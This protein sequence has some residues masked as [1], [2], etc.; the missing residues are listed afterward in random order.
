MQT[1]ALVASS[2]AD[3]SQQRELPASQ[4]SITPPAPATGRRLAFQDLK[5]TLTNEE[6]ANPGTQ[7]LIL[8][9]LTSAELDRDEFKAYVPRYYESDKRASVLEEK[10]RTNKSNEILTGTCIGLGGTIIGL[11]PTFWSNGSVGPITLGLGLLFVIGGVAGRITF[12]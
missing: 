10:L 7:K 12:K 2:A 5:R 9:M 1:P 3:A 11:A 6:L 8:E 4:P